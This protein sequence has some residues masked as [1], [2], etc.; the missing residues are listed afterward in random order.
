MFANFCYLHFP[1]RLCKIT[2]AERNK[3]SNFSLQVFLICEI[4][5]NIEHQNCKLKVRDAV[6]FMLVFRRKLQLPSARV[7]MEAVSFSEKFVSFM[8]LLDVAFQKT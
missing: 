1:V 5:H 6:Y 7:K 3:I 8:K 2:H 4:S